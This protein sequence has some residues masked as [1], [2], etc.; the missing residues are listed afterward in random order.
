MPKPFSYK[1]N[2]FFEN[3]IVTN[4][5]A[6]RSFSEHLQAKPLF[7]KKTLPILKALLVFGHF[8][9]VL[10][11]KKSARPENYF[12]FRNFY[13]SIY[14]L[15][16]LSILLIIYIMTPVF[17][18]LFIAITAYLF[19]GYINEFLAENQVYHEINTPPLFDR[20][21]NLLPLF[22]KNFPNIGLISFI[23]YFVV[24]WGYQI[25]PRLD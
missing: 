22:P 14:F 5:C 9:N 6:P 20:G 7:Q 8:K 17:K 11:W 15:F 3:F 1:L 25:P 18:E 16:F 13:R 21:H 12:F 4:V 2:K 24:R 10:F 19:I 23:V